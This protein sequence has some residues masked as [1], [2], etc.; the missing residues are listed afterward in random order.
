M[1]NVTDVRWCG[2]AKEND[3]PH[4][5]FYENAKVYLID[6]FVTIEKVDCNNKSPMLLE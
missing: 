3:E 4:R 2:F 1:E 6:F 5:Q